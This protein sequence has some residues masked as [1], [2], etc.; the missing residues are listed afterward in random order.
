MM[1][2]MLPAFELFCLLAQ[3]F[4]GEPDKYCYSLTISHISRVIRTDPLKENCK[5]DR[6]MV[7]HI[8]FRS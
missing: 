5:A 3:V 4:F 6:Q 8:N 7:L 2:A 1:F